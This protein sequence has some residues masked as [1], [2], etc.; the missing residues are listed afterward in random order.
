[1]QVDCGLFKTAEAA[2]KSLK[3]RIQIQLDCIQD[4]ITILLTAS[5]PP[6]DREG[7]KI[8]HKRLDQISLDPG[9]DFY[10]VIHVADQE[11]WGVFPVEVQE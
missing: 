5:A 9:Y 10:D 11:I 4:D 8:T 7:N 2:I 1:M 6:V 3:N